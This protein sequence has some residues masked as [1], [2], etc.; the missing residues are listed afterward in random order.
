MSNASNLKKAKYE[1][2]KPIAELIQQFRTGYSYIITCNQFK[3]LYNN[4]WNNHGTILN[5][6]NNIDND[7]SIDLKDFIIQSP[8]DTVQSYIDE[9][10]V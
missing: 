3:N 9:K 6:T 4:I 1:D 7:E 5:N 8:E 2:N 10:L